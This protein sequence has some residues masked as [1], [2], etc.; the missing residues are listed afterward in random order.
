MSQCWAALSILKELSVPVLWKTTQNQ[1]SQ[2]WLFQ[3][4]QRTINFHG[5]TSKELPL[6]SFLTF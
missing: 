2:S 5:K 6:I 1:K 3:K 4:T